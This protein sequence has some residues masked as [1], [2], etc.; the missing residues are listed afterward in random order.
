MTFMYKFSD[1]KL[2]LSAIII[3][4]GL[5]SPSF[6][7][8]ETRG[9]ASQADQGQ[10]GDQKFARDIALMQKRIAQL[11]GQ[12]VDMQVII[13]T[14]ESLVK[15]QNQVSNISDPSQSGFGTQVVSGAPVNNGQSGQSERIDILETQMRALSDQMSRLSQQS[16]NRAGGNG[17]VEQNAGQDNVQKT[18]GFYQKK[19]EQFGFGSATV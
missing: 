10:G 14:L 5:T 2:L 19:N 13:G 17:G 1:L 7:Q 9:E 3:L 18:Q 12:V 6:A 8:Q 16:Q 15:Q 4:F 11:E